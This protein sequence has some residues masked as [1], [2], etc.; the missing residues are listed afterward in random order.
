M[1]R[2]YHHYHWHPD[3]RQVS[4][5]ISTA[6]D[7]SSALERAIRYAGNYNQGRASQTSVGFLIDAYGDDSKTAAMYVFRTVRGDTMED[8]LRRVD[9]ASLVG[10]VKKAFD[11][12]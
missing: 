3:I 11:L 2:E 8:A 6:K 10:V 9:K 7:A 4:K 12:K 1:T 5:Q